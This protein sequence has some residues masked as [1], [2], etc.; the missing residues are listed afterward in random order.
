MVLASGTPRCCQLVGVT[1][2]LFSDSCKCQCL[3]APVP[4]V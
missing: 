3:A 4:L 1:L 2:W